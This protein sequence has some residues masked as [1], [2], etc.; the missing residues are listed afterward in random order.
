MENVVYFASVN[1]ALRAPETPTAIIAPN[2]A[3]LA[4]LAYG[5]EGLLVA[6]LDLAPATGLY[7]QRLAPERYGD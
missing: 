7:A 5:A 2:G 1:F 4:R 6:D 3:C